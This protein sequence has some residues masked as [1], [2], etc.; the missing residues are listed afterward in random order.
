MSSIREIKAFKT[1]KSPYI[2]QL[3][4]IFVHK[5]AI[6]MVQEY[7]LFNLEE[8]IRCKSVVILPANIKAW[9]Y[10]LLVGLEACHSHF[11]V[12]RD[13][14]PSNILLMA[15][16]TLKLADFG[17]TRR[18][19]QRMT[20]QT[21]TRWYRPPEILMGVKSYNTS[22][23]MW[24]VGA[25]FAEMFLRVPFFAA[26]TDIQ[27][28]ELICR[29][30]GTPTPEDWPEMFSLPAYLPMENFVGPDLQNMF[31]AAS[32]DALDLLK[33]LLIFNPLKRITCEGALLHEYFKNKPD[34]TLPKDLPMPPAKQDSA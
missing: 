9:L 30:L 29:A 21:I 20:P 7:A 27:Q 12:H 28:L 16:G 32:I 13:I 4:D 19:G 17:L 22:V 26:E 14:K 3:L 23:D 34:A 31:G 24:S 25:V 8:I 5:T 15:D 11:F 18:I 2:L 1:I 33:K 6:H 10:M